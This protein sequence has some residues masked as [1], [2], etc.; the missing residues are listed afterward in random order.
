MQTLL[1]EK[2]A[3]QF[4]EIAEDKLKDLVR[5]KLIPAYMVGGAFLRFKKEELEVLRNMLGEKR[6]L[7]DERV[8]HQAFSRVK[9]AERF[10]EILRAN[11]V[12][13]LAAFIIILV[14]FIFFKR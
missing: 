3:A 4:L 9:G 12:Y 8:F 11:D 6:A 13:L 10:M 5:A 1:N 14:L 7:N 2:E